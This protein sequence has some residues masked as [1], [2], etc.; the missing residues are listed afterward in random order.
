MVI[1][2]ALANWILRQRKLILEI[3]LLK[4][5]K[6]SRHAFWIYCDYCGSFMKFPHEGL[7][8]DFQPGWK[9][10]VR[11]LSLLP[12]AK[13]HAPTVVK[14]ICP[15]PLSTHIL[16][17]GRGPFHDI[18]RRSAHLQDNESLCVRYRLLPEIL[19]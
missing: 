15:A 17:T 7:M 10:Y 9:R 19:S 3:N 6:R 12:G 11:L 4:Y 2:D 16:S 14:L 18:P 5:P 1:C 13:D 8:N